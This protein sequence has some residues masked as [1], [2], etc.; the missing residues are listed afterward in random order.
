[1]VNETEQKNAQQVS[2]RGKKFIDDGEIH[3]YEI[4]KVK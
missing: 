1:M 2:Q 3:E 4:N